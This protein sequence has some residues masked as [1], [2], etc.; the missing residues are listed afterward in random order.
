MKKDELTKRLAREAR[1]S[2]A[3]AADRLDQV[4]H[5]ILESLRRGQAAALP[6]LGKFVPGKRTGFEFEAPAP[7]KRR[8]K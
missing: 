4:I 7:K 5:D 2:D 8:R 1:V 6:G 3:A